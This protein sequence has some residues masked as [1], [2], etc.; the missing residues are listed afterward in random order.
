MHIFSNYDLP[1]GIFADSWARQVILAPSICQIL[2]SGRN[3][4]KID[5][6]NG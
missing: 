6:E 3:V 4:A 2:G 1:T 5:F